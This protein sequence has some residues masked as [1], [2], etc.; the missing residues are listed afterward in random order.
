MADKHPPDTKAAMA[1]F[2][3]GFPSRREVLRLLRLQTLHALSLRLGS[4]RLAQQRPALL[5]AAQL[6]VAAGGG[7]SRE[8]A[9][10]PNDSWE[11]WEPDDLDIDI[12]MS[13]DSPLLPPP[14]ST[15]TTSSTCTKVV[16]GDW[17]NSDST[18]SSLG[19]S[20]SASHCRVTICDL[21]TTPPMLPPLPPPM[22]PPMPPPIPPPVPPPMPPPMP[23]AAA[24]P[25]QGPCHPVA[26]DSNSASADSRSDKCQLRRCGRRCLCRREE[27]ASAG[28]GDVGDAVAAARGHATYVCSQVECGSP[29][30]SF[31]GRSSS[32]IGKSSPA[33]AGSPG[34][35]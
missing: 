29:P 7:P 25:V 34:K 32:G 1:A 8:T 19:S 16:S 5:A 13:L 4:S 24:P 21:N 31:Y 11:A 26:G 30:V 28:A 15:C 27:T 17:D 20:N 2:I 6:A 9:D 23:H 12:V 22:P 10:G 18:L 14:S 3:Y 33:L 35:G